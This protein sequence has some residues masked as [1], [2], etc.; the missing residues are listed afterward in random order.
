MAK[1]DY[2]DF[3]NSTECWICYNDYINGDVKVSDYCDI[4]GGSAH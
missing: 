2:E 4:T 1:K 3:E